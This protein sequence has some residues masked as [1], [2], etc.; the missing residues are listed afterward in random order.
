MNQTSHLFLFCL[1]V[2][3]LLSACEKQKLTGPSADFNHAFTRGGMAPDIVQ[4]T[5]TE[6]DADEYEWHIIETLDDNQ[7][8]VQ[9]N[10]ESAGLYNV[11]LTVTSG[12]SSKTYSEEVELFDFPTLGPALTFV[13]NDG[14]VGTITIVTE[15]ENEVISPWLLIANVDPDSHAGMD[16]NNQ[17]NMLYYTSSTSIKE[18]SPNGT[19]MATI[20]SEADLE[21]LED[22]I[23][24]L[25]VDSEDQKVYFV[26]N[27][28]DNTSI[29]STLSLID[30]GRDTIGYY[31][32]SH[33]LHLTLDNKAKRYYFTA[34]GS[35]KIHY[36][37]AT[38]VIGSTNGNNQ[39]KYALVFDNKNDYLYYINDDNH[40]DDFDIIR[41][42]PD[43]GFQEEIVVEDASTGTVPIL[44]I[45][46][47]EDDQVLYWSDKDNIYR[48]NLND[49]YPTKEIIIPNVNA[50]RALAVG[51][52]SN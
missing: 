16:Y 46:I 33:I 19:D 17:N 29:I 20:F 23:V 2:V 48:L 38:G 14:D 21:P 32:S 18:C 41:V 37:N 12:E 6:N 13:Q 51:N 34:E 27:K 31:S 49:N 3:L 44:D 11:E 15:N 30:N 25:V 50:P 8:K 1:L 28:T 39:Q 42:R 26:I 5:A 7:Q 4:F 24:D 10:F 36:G 45:D 40:D 47:D 52:F 22:N 9:F 43:N 35:D